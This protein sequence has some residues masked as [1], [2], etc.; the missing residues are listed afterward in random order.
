MPLLISIMIIITL[1]LTYMMAVFIGDRYTISLVSDAASAAPFSGYFSLCT[2]IIAILFIITSYIRCKQVEFF[3]IK[4]FKLNNNNDDI[5]DDDDDDNGNN[6]EEDDTTT[7]DEHRTNGYLKKSTK[8]EENFQID[9]EIIAK[10]SW[11][12]YRYFICMILVAIGLTFVGNFP[13]NYHPFPHA[14]GVVLILFSL[15][16]FYDQIYICQKLYE[17]DRIESQPI[18]M[19][20]LSCLIIIGWFIAIATGLIA[21][22]QQESKILTLMNND[23]RMKWTDEQPG[24]QWFKITVLAEWITFLL[25]SPIYLML[26]NRMKQFHN[27]QK[28]FTN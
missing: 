26:T 17:F 18:S 27:W 23:L 14:F 1:P 9:E 12:N 2:D 16:A 13:C 24:S 19:T 22:F 15:I 11:Q 20:I 8:T 6:N 3:L 4:Q 21:S 25:Y 10:L 5:V 7:T 28:I